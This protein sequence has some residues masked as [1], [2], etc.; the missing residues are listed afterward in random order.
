ME[1]ID[2]Q[3]DDVA[4]YTATDASGVVRVIHSAHILGG[5]I[6][7]G[8]G[9]TLRGCYL[10]G[11]SIRS[12]AKIVLRGCASKSD[13]WQ[14]GHHGIGWRSVDTRVALLTDCFTTRD[15]RIEGRVDLHDTVVF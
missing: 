6:I 4:G 7:M 13:R 1:L 11:V 12:D 15:C 8:A 9:D 5:E 14:E 3:V 10:D 2:C